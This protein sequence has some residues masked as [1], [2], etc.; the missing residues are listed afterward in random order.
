MLHHIAISS[1]DLA[2]S[3]KFYERHFGFQTTH[4]FTK[5]GW[6]GRAAY[7]ES[8][9]ARLEI[10]EFEDHTFASKNDAD[11]RVIGLKHIAFEVDDI[12]TFSDHLIQ[13]G[14]DV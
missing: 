14:V 4:E 9:D 8:T 2:R 1:S 5:P 12:H 10:F 11:L 6:S 3:A 7:L 13:Q